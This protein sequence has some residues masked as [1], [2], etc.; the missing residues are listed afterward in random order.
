MHTHEE[1]QFLPGVKQAEA[2]QQTV[3]GGFGEHSHNK[4]LIYNKMW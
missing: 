2:G 3:S 4:T 1:N